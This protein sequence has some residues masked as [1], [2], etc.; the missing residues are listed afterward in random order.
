[1]S[2]LY[3]TKQVGR[4]IARVY[5]SESGYKVIVRNAGNVVDTKEF[6]H[7]EQVDRFLDTLR[8]N[9]D[10]KNDLLKKIIREE[11]E[12]TLAEVDYDAIGKSLEELHEELTKNG[13]MKYSI[14]KGPL[15]SHV[16]KVAPL[17]LEVVSKMVEHPVNHLKLY[18]INQVHSTNETCNPVEYQ[19]EIV[20]FFENTDAE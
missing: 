11:V 5:Q 13:D 14:R 9:I 19:Q 6:K 7:P 2:N 1:M 20:Y 15:A 18:F 10:M 17:P 16:R 4:K 12:N 3:R 8:E